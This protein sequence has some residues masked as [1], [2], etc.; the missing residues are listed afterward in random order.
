[1]LVIGCEAETEASEASVI[2]YR[3][4]TNSVTN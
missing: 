4:K 3:T 2:S 1:M